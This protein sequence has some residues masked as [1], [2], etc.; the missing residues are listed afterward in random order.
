MYP[1]PEEIVDHAPLTCTDGSVLSTTI[2]SATAVEAGHERMSRQATRT[3]RSTR[4][5]V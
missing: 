1:S 3:R 5:T 2:S 4:K